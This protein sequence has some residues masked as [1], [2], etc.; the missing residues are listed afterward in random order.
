MPTRNE[1]TPPADAGPVFSEVLG[2]GPERAARERARME[3]WALIDQYALLPDATADE[4]FKSARNDL[5]ALIDR[6]IPASID[7]RVNGESSKE[8]QALE[9]FLSARMDGGMDGSAMTA[10]MLERVRPQEA[11]LRVEIERLR[12]ALQRI[13]HFTSA[14]PSLSESGC[15]R[16][17]AQIEHA[18]TKALGAL[19]V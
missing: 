1:Q 13:T 8:R 19:N 11:R 3:L 15:G 5:A 18:A 10:A 7:S 9:A 14:T 4:T 2:L 17:L 6:L 16:L 12:A